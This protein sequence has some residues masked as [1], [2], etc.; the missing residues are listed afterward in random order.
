MFASWCRLSMFS[1][2]FAAA[3]HC[4]TG[5]FHDFS[6][7]SEYCVLVKAI[8]CRRGRGCTSCTQ[9]VYYNRFVRQTLLTN[10]QLPTLTFA[11][12]GL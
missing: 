7:R 2:R 9:N 12:G 1:T 11:G 10:V 6:T 5:T 3:A 8:S 4:C